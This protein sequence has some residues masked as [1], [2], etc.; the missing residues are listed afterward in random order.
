MKRTITTFFVSLMLIV[1]AFAQDTLFVKNSE[2]STAWEG[3]TAYT[4]LQDAIDAAQAGDM[5]WV[6]QGTYLPTSTFGN[7][8]DIRC[9]SFV[10]KDNVSLYGGFE[11]T[12]NSV[13][14]RPM[15]YYELLYP[16]ILSGEI[17]NTPDV[18]TDNSYH[19]VYGKNTST[20]T[21]DGFTISN[22]CANRTSYLSDQDGAG[23]YMGD[24]WILRNCIITNNTAMRNGGGVWVSAT[25]T[26]YNCFLSNNSVTAVSSGGGGAYFDNRSFD[27]TVA[28]SDCIFKENSCSATTTPTSSSRNG[29]GAMSA[30]QNTIIEGCYFILNTCTNPGGA[31]ICSNGNSFSNCMFYMNQASSGACIYGGSSSS[32]RVSNC[33]FANNE[34]TGNG[35]TIYITGSSCCA[36]NCT[37]VNNNATAG[38]AVYG[39]SG[40]TLFNSIV[41]N[42][43]TATE[44][45][46][47]GTSNVTCKYTAIQGVLASGEGNLNVTTEDIAF[48][49][50]CPIIGVPEEL[51]E[52]Q[53]D[54]IFDAD[55]SI[56]GNS[57]CKDA[58]SIAILS[59][60]GYQFPE[61]DLNGD[62]RVVGSAIDLGCFENP[63]ENVAPEVTWTVV[64]TLYNPDEPGT[65]SVGIAFT[66]T[67][68]N[69][70]YTYF[71]TAGTPIMMD[72]NT[73]TVV[74]DF[75]GS[76][77]YTISYTDGECGAETEVT[78]TID[79]LFAPV[80]IVENE[81]S[82]LNLYPIPAH[83]TLTVESTSPIREITVYDQ[84]GRTVTVETC[85]G[86]SLQQVVNTSALPAGIYLLNVVTE[87]GTK[88][89][90]FVKN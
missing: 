50:P 11:G 34:A 27:A 20:V 63:C 24:N 44:S 42:N 16:T 33:L 43:G 73:I 79:S 56:D 32:L 64:D 46:V 45:Q 71:L 14:D 87:K 85:H 41:W 6:E 68:Y 61:T 78:I 58:G 53:M 18:A 74:F 9:K 28:A 55:Y 13:E 5:I 75:P 7:N 4:D 30:G 29:G 12:E 84:M 72:G 40:L 39:S 51:T 49:A 25:G 26:L 31:I 19:V 21:L 70:D 35:G 86:A 36:V 10:L 83:N 81:P 57:V 15:D 22:G 52:E 69:E 8:N 47:S 54:S 65:G 38:A 76:Y 23:V 67:N 66:I 80:G 2:S 3:R 77:T 17:A 1:S 60:S 59:L 62:D 82:T 90:K 48:L 37:Y 88:T 89:A